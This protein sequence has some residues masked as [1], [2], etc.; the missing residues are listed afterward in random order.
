MS[1]ASKGI[2]W[3]KSWVSQPQPVCD[4]KEG[5]HEAVTV[6]FSFTDQH[7]GDIFYT[8]SIAPVF[9]SNIAF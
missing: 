6:T 3:R 7:G 2:G 4:F 9:F 8:V 5:I 1:W